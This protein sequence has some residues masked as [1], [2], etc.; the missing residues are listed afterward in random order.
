MGS[1][2]LQVNRTP[3]PGQTPEPPPYASPL[4]PPPPAPTPLWAEPQPEPIRPPHST[5]PQ[6]GRPRT[7]T[8]PV[9]LVGHHRARSDQRDEAERRRQ[10]GRRLCYSRRRRL[11][12]G[13]CYTAGGGAAPGAGLA[14]CAAPAR[15]SRLLGC[16]A[17]HGARVGVGPTRSVWAFSTAGP[18]AIL[19][20]KA[21]LGGNY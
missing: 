11:G 2:Y 13:L 1:Q 19:G 21:R 5:L 8:R 12:R 18:L 17:T 14:G 10:L 3:P 16:A 15:P 20:K 9:A 6:S 4:P 7:V